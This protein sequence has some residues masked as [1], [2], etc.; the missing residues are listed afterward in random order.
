MS[1]DEK[2][3]SVS[4]ASPLSNWVIA[5]QVPPNRR[6]N[7]LKYLKLFGYKPEH[8]IRHVYIAWFFSKRKLDK[9][10]QEKR[11]AAV[12]RYG[13]TTFVVVGENTRPVINGTGDKPKK[14]VDAVSP[15]YVG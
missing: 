15:G 8:T 5:A 11:Q 9:R 3:T 10:E 12:K 13:G 4:A 14:K 7:I 1:L 6:E 2:K